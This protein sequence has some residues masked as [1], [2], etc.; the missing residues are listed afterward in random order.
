MDFRAPSSAI[1]RFSRL[2]AA[3]R[4]PLHGSPGAAGYDLSAAE[5]ALIPVGGRASIATDIAVQ[6]PLGCYG[7]VAPRSGLALDSGIDVGAGVI[8]ADFRGNIRVLLFNFGDSPFRVNVGDRIAQLI[9]EVC[10]SAVVVEVDSLTPTG[11]GVAGF[12]STGK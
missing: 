11:R 2:S 1:L 8:D 10:V 7:R 12:G 5:Y 9:L 3:A 6:L 4:A